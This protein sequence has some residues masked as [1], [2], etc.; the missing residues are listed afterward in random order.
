MRDFQHIE[1]IR[2]AHLILQRKG[3]EIHLVKGRAGFQR[4]QRQVPFPQQLKDKLKMRSTIYQ[5][6]YQKDQNR[7]MSDG[8]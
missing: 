8:Y 2:I 3:H 6:L 1:H 7:A 4:G 5:E